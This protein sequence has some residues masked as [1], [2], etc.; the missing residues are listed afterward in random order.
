MCHLFHL[1]LVKQ[2]VVNAGVTILLELLD[3]KSV[4][5]QT[6]TEERSTLLPT[7][8]RTLHIQLSMDLEKQIT[9]L[10]A[11]TTT[12][13]GVHLIVQLTHVE[14]MVVMDHLWNATMRRE[15]GP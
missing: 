3:P 1:E 5:M 8:Q 4:V 7:V 13:M 12:T 10:T 2:L 6:T 11:P 15:D 14:V 9:L